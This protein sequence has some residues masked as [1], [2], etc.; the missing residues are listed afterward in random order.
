MGHYQMRGSRGNTRAA[1][2]NPSY[3][4]IFER[5]RDLEYTVREARWITKRAVQYLAEHPDWTNE[6][7]IKE[8][9]K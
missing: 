3:I 2:K 7:A 8:V 1:H 9:M 4:E 6:Q 5:L